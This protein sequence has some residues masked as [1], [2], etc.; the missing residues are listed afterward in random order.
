MREDVF[1]KEITLFQMRVTTEDEGTDAEVHVT[2]QLRQHLIWISHEGA[3]AATAREADARPDM[4]F[5]EEILA[6]RA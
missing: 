1:G 2:M 3:A 6:L 4:V 5:D